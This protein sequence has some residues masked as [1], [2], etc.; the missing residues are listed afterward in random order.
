[1]SSTSLPISSARFAAALT[2]LPTSSLHAKIAELQNS[3]SHLQTSNLELKEYAQQG[4]KD[5]YEAMM[6]N[7]DVV[8]RME[9]RIELV[10]REIVEV[11]GLPL[12]SAGVVKEPGEEGTRMGA[13]RGDENERS[14]MVDGEIG[15]EAL[16]DEEVQRRLEEMRNE[17]VPRGGQNGVDAASGSQEEDGVF[18]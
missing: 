15:V 17:P 14:T 9:E 10:K 12:T 11:R 1:M 7:L 6:E 5:C 4:D 8:R 2:S 13:A 16:S 18:L 3:I